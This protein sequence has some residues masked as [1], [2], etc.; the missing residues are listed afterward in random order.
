[1]LIVATWFD[2]L[3]KVDAQCDKLTTVV[4]QS[5]LSG[6]YLW[7][8]MCQYLTDKLVH[9]VYPTEYTIHLHVLHDARDAVRRAGPSAAVYTRY[10]LLSPVLLFDDCN[11]VCW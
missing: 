11:Y 2:L 8:S 5:A 9:A 7:Q 1:M 4:A 3:T 6:H 10:T